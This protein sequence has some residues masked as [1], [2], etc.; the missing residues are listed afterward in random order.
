MQVLDYR[1]TLV[2]N[3]SA[4]VEGTNHRL[5]AFSPKCVV[6]VGNGMVELNSEQKRSAFEHFR[7]NSKDVEI[8][9]YDELFRKLDV[10]ANL[11]SL[12]RIK[13]S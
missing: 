1:G 13:N 9:T 3:L 6:I 2:K 10:L 12:V 7:A 4:V 5:S 8:T 11:F